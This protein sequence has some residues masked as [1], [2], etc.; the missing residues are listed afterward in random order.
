MFLMD[1]IGRHSQEHIYLCVYV[2]GGIGGFTCTHAGL[3][4]R[5]KVNMGCLSLLLSTSSFE[6]GSLSLYLAIEDRL[7]G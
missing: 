2:E 4:W 6:T 7:T 5:P 3:Q 1:L